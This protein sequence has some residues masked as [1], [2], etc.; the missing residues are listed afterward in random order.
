MIHNLAVSLSVTTKGRIKE[1]EYNQEIDGAVVLG[2]YD[3]L[4]DSIGIL[5]TFVKKKRKILK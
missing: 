4:D 3:A 5:K 1:L 2:I